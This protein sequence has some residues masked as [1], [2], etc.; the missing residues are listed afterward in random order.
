MVDPDGEWGKEEE[1][2]ESDGR[3]P[4]GDGFGS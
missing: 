1:K 4:G 3:D 2:D